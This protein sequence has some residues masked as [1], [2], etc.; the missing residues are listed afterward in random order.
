MNS[1]LVAISTLIKSNIG[2]KCLASFL[3]NQ[4][5][6][7]YLGLANIYRGDAIKKKTDLIE[8]IIYGCTINKLEKK[9]IK[10]ISTSRAT[11]IL[12]NNEIQ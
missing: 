9:G 2:E 7:D 5:M 12:K 10:D 11:K 8:M 4:G 3:I 6:R 1:S